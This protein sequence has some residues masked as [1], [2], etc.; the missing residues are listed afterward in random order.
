MMLHLIFYK[1]VRS[2]CSSGTSPRMQSDRYGRL[3]AVLNYREVE[4][5]PK[6]TLF[7][8]LPKFVPQTSLSQSRTG[9]KIPPLHVR[10]PPN[11]L[12]IQSIKWVT[13]QPTLIA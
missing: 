4:Q 12:T 3:Y 11:K 8:L 6:P 5:S 7:S 13:R 10:P 1:A 2:P 9:L